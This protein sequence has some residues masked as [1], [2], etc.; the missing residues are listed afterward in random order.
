VF[1]GRFQPLHNG[2]L[3]TMLTALGLANQVLI[4]VGSSN[5]SRSVRNPWSFAE[6]QR[7]IGLAVAQA[8][9]GRVSGRVRIRPLPDILYPANRWQGQV[10]AEV[11]AELDRLALD[12]CTARVGLIGHEKDA[13]S[14]YLRDFPEWTG[15][16][17]A[18]VHGLDA[19]AVRN[20]LFA[21]PAQ[22]GMAADFGLV[23]AAV[24]PAVWAGLLAWANGAAGTPGT[25]E[26]R[27]LREEHAVLQDYRAPWA[28]APHPPTFV[29]G[30]A[31]LIHEDRIL[32]V[33]RARAPGRGLW[34]LPGGFLDPDERLLDCALRELAEEAGIA[35]P[36]M[37]VE[38]TEAFDHPERSQRGRTITHAFR[39]ALPP[40]APLPIATAGDDG[41]DPTWIL[42]E[43]F[44]GMA[45]ELYEDHWQI[46][47]KMLGWAAQVPAL[48]ASPIFDAGVASVF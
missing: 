4:L 39:L 45:T 1:I 48:S 20:A 2:H 41:L 11:A 32:L 13:T 5:R 8:C 34:A 36:Q 37:R 42:L 3:Q 10:R 31:V 15:V 22:P 12:A 21:D 24:P 33:R 38:A 9:D 40:G 27:R 35:E 46:V 6:R 29:T 16:P 7:M 19:T 23:E 43:E 44:K 25:Q 26:L 17:Q 14:G 47:A 30:D 28:S 18:N